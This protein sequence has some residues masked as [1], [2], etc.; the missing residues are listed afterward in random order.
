MD[1]VL[2]MQ[3][4]LITRLKAYSALTAIVG[5]KVYDE[6]P[7]EQNGTVPPA[8]YPYVSIGPSNFVSEDA[9]CI[10]GG[11][12]MI[13]VDAW[14]RGPGFPEVRRVADAVRKA[15]RGHTFT[16][17]TNALVDFEHWRTDY[18]RDGTLHHA[19]I[20]FTGI[21]EQP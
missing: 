2:E 15:V 7:A 21:V 12:F 11:D 10:S 3:G 20:R 16:L 4:V 5:S 8:T 14:S 17:T 1:P 9:D 18:V 13:Q 6:P 19:S